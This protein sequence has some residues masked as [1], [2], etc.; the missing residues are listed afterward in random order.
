MRNFNYQL[1]N[2]IINEIR[3]NS[4]VT[5]E[6]IANKYGYNV[7]TIRRCFKYLKDNKKLI[8]VKSSKNREWKLL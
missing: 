1:I 6:F 2:E 4:K 3:K 7:R 5:Q 8:L